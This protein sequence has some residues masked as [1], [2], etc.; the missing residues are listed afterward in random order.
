[1]GGWLIEHVSWRAV[2]FLNVPI[3]FAV[4]LLILL[5]VP[6]SRDEENSGKL[7][8]LGAALATTSL[9]AIVYSLIQSSTSGWQNSIVLASLVIGIVLLGA[10][11]FSRSSKRNPMLPLNLFRSRNFTGQIC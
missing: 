4:I 8:L 1:M 6:E 2:F 11:C 10:L 5:F 9:G 3:A 7:D